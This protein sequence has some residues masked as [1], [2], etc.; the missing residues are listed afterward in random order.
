MNVNDAQAQQYIAG[1]TGSGGAD[2]YDGGNA[3]NAQTLLVVADGDASPILP[4]GGSADFLVDYAIIAINKTALRRVNL[5]FANFNDPH[6]VRFYNTALN[7]AWQKETEETLNLVDFFHP[8]QSFSNYQ[9]QTFNI[10]ALSSINFDIGNFD[11]TFGEVS[12]LMAQAEYLPHLTD[13]EDNILY[14]N[15]KNSPRYTMGQF[16]TL[17]GAVKTTSSW[18][19]WNVDPS[20]EPGYTGIE[21][22][23][24]FTNP[25]N[26]TVRITILTAN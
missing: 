6:N 4:P 17:T 13:I 2:N 1:V 19:G 24:V 25:T 16:M 21:P 14:W 3:S 15:Y 22:G 20:L 9:K 18:F 23:F 12:L 7:V 11:T 26:Y 5:T 10:A 8:L